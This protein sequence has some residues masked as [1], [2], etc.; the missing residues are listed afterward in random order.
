MLFLFFAACTFAQADYVAVTPVHATAVVAD[1][2][3]NVLMDSVYTTADKMPEPVGGLSALAKNVKYPKKAKKDGVQGTVFVGVTI[4]EKG[5][6]ILPSIM[7]GIGHGCDEAA[8]N[9]VKKTRFTPAIKNWKAVKSRI[10]I[11]IA[12]KLSDGKTDNPIAQDVHKDD[13]NPAG[14]TYKYVEEMPSV[15]GGMESVLKG[16][17]YPESAKQRKIEGKVY[18]HLVVNEEGNTENVTIMKSLDPDCDAASINFVKTL[19]WNPGKQQGKPVKVEV[20]LPIQF[21]LK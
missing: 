8:I 4:D 12:F 14:G 10:T 5:N 18:V 7:R 9:A 17:T 11:P 16:V 15:V 6:P 20:V 3:V 2:S 13:A 19:K 21:S 1:I